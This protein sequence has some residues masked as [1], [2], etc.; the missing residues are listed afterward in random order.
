M[1]SAVAFVLVVGICGA[2]H[3]GTVPPGVSI[4]TV[5]NPFGVPALGTGIGIYVV[6]D[7]NTEIAAENWKVEGRIV[8]HDAGPAT[9]VFLIDPPKVQSQRGVGLADLFE[10]AENNPAVPFEVNDSYWGAYFVQSISPS[11]FN[12]SGSSNPAGLPGGLME[13]LDGKDLDTAADASELL[14]YVVIT[15]V[16]TIEGTLVFEGGA[17]ESIPASHG[18]DTEGNIFMIPEPTAGAL[19]GM[20][21]V[22]LFGL[23]GR[24]G[25]RAS[26]RQD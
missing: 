19:V 14:L 1:R 25:V 23:R 13:L 22:G 16:V 12:G 10:P 4:S 9:S 15:D 3:A 18:L 17:T 7:G 20:C 8:N 6:S 11:T 21:L 2:G 24:R 26:V 5:V